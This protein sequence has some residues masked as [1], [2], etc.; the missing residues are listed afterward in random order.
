MPTRSL[1]S[2]HFSVNVSSS[3]VT[4]QAS[5]PIPFSGNWPALILSFQFSWAGKRCTC[6][7]VC[8]CMY[9]HTSDQIYNPACH[10][11]MQQ[12]DVVINSHNKSSNCKAKGWSAGRQQ[13]LDALLF[14]LMLEH[15]TAQ[16]LVAF[17]SCVSHNFHCKTFQRKYSPTK[18]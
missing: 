11:T 15:C 5:P 16:L 17:F 9:Q 3:F 18:A 6:V 10:I 4:A 14:C 8:V 7:C 12:E 2:H 1:E 13:E